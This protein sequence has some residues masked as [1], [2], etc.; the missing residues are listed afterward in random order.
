MLDTEIESIVKE[1]D[2]LHINDSKI[3]EYWNKITHLLSQNE[4]ETINFLLNCN[5]YNIIATVAV[6]FIDISWRLQSKRFIKCIEFVENKF[7][8]A[9]IKHMVKAAKN[10]ILDD[11]DTTAPPV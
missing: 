5:D 2:A 11:E 7:P 3:Y 10:A 6:A 9:N 4:Q 8:K 1:I